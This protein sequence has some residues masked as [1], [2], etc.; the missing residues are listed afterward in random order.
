[1]EEWQRNRAVCKADLEDVMDLEPFTHFDL[2]RMRKVI[3]RLKATVRLVDQSVRPTSGAAQAGQASAD[4]KLHFLMKP[5]PYVLRVYVVRTRNLAPPPEIEQPNPYLKVWHANP[6]FRDILM[7][8][9]EVDLENRLFSPEWRASG[10]DN[11]QQPPLPPI[12]WRTLQVPGS[13][14]SRG[15]L[16]TWIELWPKGLADSCPAMDISL[17]PPEPFEMRVVVWRARKVPSQDPITKMNDLYI[18]TILTEV[19]DEFSGS[20]KRTIDETDTH[21]RA[22][23]GVGS[24]NWRLVFN[25]ELPVHEMRLRFQAWDQV[26]TTD[27]APKGEGEAHMIRWE[28]EDQ[29]VNRAELLAIQKA[30]T[31]PR[32]PSGRGLTICTDSANSIRQLESMRT[33][34]RSME[35]HQQRDLLYAILVNIEALVAA[36]HTVSLLKVKAHAGITGNEKADEAA[37]QACT[38]GTLTEAWDN[39][40]TIKVKP[41]VP[42]GDSDCKELKGKL[43]V[44]KYVTTLLHERQAQGENRLSTK[45]A[46]LQGEPTTWTHQLKKEHVF[47]WEAHHDQAQQTEEEQ[48]II[49]DPTPNPQQR[50]DQAPEEE[51]RQIKGMMEQQ[52]EEEMLRMQEVEEQH[53]P[54]EEMD[55]TV[56]TQG[57][58]PQPAEAS[59]QP[60]DEGEIFEKLYEL[61]ERL[62]VPQEERNEEE[63]FE[64]LNELIVEQ[65]EAPQ[66]EL[67][68][69]RQ[70]HHDRV[71]EESRVHAMMADPAP[72]TRWNQQKHDMTNHRMK[73]RNAPPVKEGKVTKNWLNKPMEHLKGDKPLHKI[74][75]DFWK[76]ATYA[77]R[78]TILKC[79][80]RILP[81]QDYETAKN[82]TGGG[83]KCTLEG[84][85][86]PGVDYAKGFLMRVGHALGGCNNPQMRGMFSDRADAHADELKHILDHHRKGGCKV[87]AYTGRKRDLGVKPRVLPNYILTRGQCRH[88]GK[89]NPGKNDGPD[90]IPSFVDMVMIEGLEDLEDGLTKNFLLGLT[91][92]IRH[93][94]MKVLACS[95]REGR[96]S[97]WNERKEDLIGANDYIGEAS[98][99]ISGLVLRAL[100]KHRSGAKGTSAMVSFPSRACSDLSNEELKAS[101]IPTASQISTPVEGVEGV[102]DE[103]AQPLLHDHPG[104]INVIT[105]LALP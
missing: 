35:H 77:V 30:M 52:D 84:C 31:L 51:D 41:M 5:A 50:T 64:I 40:E 8:G 72:R 16:E 74:A 97:S 1:M 38:T 96:P 102:S 53:E 42:D 58:N 33:K 100:K 46:E 24:F 10:A 79:R 88:D 23:K 47:R 2:Y 66:G 94:G 71:T 19:A 3:G 80:L 15:V 75:N 92:L 9:T 6:L 55:R 26:T 91:H 48:T 11:P 36:G 73:N 63:V 70:T 61:V 103:M 60:S 65:Q 68:S 39:D 69:G 90:T 28:G 81:A 27:A 76:R 101:N 85:G 83:G 54:W 86:H 21:W 49:R 62:E 25:F 17:P 82:S 7:G 22:K 59:P 14:V 13:K 34:P 4:D 12:E 37:K 78:K 56:H 104:S 44:Q 98:L 45:M 43:A 57:G 20:V 67:E 18:R 93:D 32:P 87:L 95:G 29:E 99:D 105:Q 89:D